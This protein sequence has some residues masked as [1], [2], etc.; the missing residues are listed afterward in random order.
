MTTVTVKLTGSR[1]D[2]GIVYFGDFRELWDGLSACLRVTEAVVAPEH[3]PLRYRIVNLEFGSAS[4]AVAAI[5]PA[6]GRD[7][8]REVVGLFSSTVSAIQ[9]GEETDPRFNPDALKVFRRLALPLAKRNSTLLVDTTEITAQFIANI[10]K[11]LGATLPSDG[12][13]SGTIERVNLHGR[14]EF[15]LYP[16]I[17]GYAITCRFP[18]RMWPKVRTAL[19]RHVTVVGKLFYRGD[20]PYPDKVQVTGIDI[21]PDDSSLPT[22][23]ELRG[24]APN[25]TGGKSAVDFVRALRDE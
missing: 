4:L 16:A 11:I 3:K 8:S 19:K 18:E 13:V 17:D 24:S 22:L 9:N 10:D 23:T 20:S 15:V 21:H 7:H 5:P 14:F 2:A 12:V 6:K 1:E 25:T